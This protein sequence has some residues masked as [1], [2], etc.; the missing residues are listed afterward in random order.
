MNSMNR[1]RVLRG[2][3]GG[4]ATT[5]ALP[6]LN[7]F[8][9]GNGDALADGKPMPTRF[10]SWF[11]GLGIARGAFN[12]KQTGFNWEITPE[13]ESLKPVKHLF[14]VFTDYM[15]YRDSYAAACHYS[16]WVATRSGQFPAQR[17]DRPGETFD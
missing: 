13:L 2:M 8:L 16:G 11:W 4:G 1:R 7:C 5:V 17:M 15:V 6:L 3:M 14:N 9:N 10:G 12:P